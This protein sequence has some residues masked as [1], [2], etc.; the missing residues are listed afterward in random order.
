MILTLLAA[1][2]GG[3]MQA[4]I[5]A[6]FNQAD[7]VWFAW[8]PLLFVI[9]QA[10]PKRAFLCGLLTGV[11]MWCI[12]LHWMV[13][14]SDYGGPLPLVLLGIAF[15][16]IYSGLY[17]G[18]VAYTAASLRKRFTDTEPSAVRTLLTLIAEPLLF[19]GAEYLR[20]TLLTGWTWNPIGLAF[21]TYLPLLQSA[22]LAGAYLPGMLVILANTAVTTII[23]RMVLTVRREQIVTHL[24]R[25]QRIFQ[26]CES[27]V[28]LLLISMTFFWGI[29]RMRTVMSNPDTLDL[30]IAA[31]A[32]DHSALR[33]QAKDYSPMKEI[34]NFRNPLE[35]IG[36]LSPHLVIFPES[37]FPFSLP[38]AAIDPFIRECTRLARAP[39]L[40]GGTY[41]PSANV[42]YNASFLF[43]EH[44]PLQYYAKRHLVPF[45]EYVP[46]DK[47]FTWLQRFVPTGVSCT[48]GDEIR[49]LPVKIAGGQTIQVAPMICYESSI[50]YIARD[51]ARDGAQ[52]LVNQS[53][54]AWYWPSAEATQHAKQSILRAVETG[55]P[56]VRSSN[57]GENCAISA[58][59]RVTPQIIPFHVRIAK[60]PIQ[61]PYTRYG[62]WL[63]GIPAAIALVVTTGIL[64]YLAIKARR[65][66]KVNL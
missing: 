65:K 33:H 15:L 26:I 37:S 36:L 53:N 32:T 62:D 61:T 21:D 6:P 2:S 30:R 4:L 13:R 64:L 40:T 38:D 55:L 18:I 43:P 35:V 57:Q 59:G 10:N 28:P 66:R 9:R 34:T 48:P 54:D 12:T 19:A 17:T 8:V 20:C 52:L 11:V 58:T 5:W 24:T 63:L 49:T 46:F 1:L 56:V 22:S 7:A 3:I 44:T 45:G 27:L 60:T 51:A 31:I 14:L 50:A 41:W 23:W 39:I 29:Q 25:P 16:A 42:C 47:T